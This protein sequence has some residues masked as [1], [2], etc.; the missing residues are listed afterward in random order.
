M[1]QSIRPHC[2]ITFGTKR[3]L[4]QKPIEWKKRIRTDGQDCSEFVFDTQADEDRRSMRRF[5][6]IRKSETGPFCTTP[7]PKRRI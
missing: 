7:L 5:L 1:N 2:Y 6:K 4:R 3:R